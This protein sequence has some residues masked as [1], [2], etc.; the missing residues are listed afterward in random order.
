MTWDRIERD[1]NKLAASFSDKFEGLTQQELDDLSGKRDQLSAALQTKY[2]YTKETAD[3]QLEDWKNS[4]PD[5]G[6]AVPTSTSGDP[7]Y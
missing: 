5:G 6:D 2:G 3:S 1:W 7:T 4:L